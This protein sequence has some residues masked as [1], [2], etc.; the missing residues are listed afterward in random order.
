MDFKSSSLDR[1]QSC[2][3]KLCPPFKREVW[4]SVSLEDNPRDTTR[5]NRATIGRKSTISDLSHLHINDDPLGSESVVSF[6]SMSTKS[7]TAYLRRNVTD[8]SDSTAHARGVSDSPT[9][10]SR[11]GSCPSV[12]S[13]RSAVLE[14]LEPV[15]R[16]LS[17]SHM[18]TSQ[19]TTTERRERIKTSL[20]R[21]SQSVVS[22]AKSISKSNESNRENAPV[23]SIAEPPVN[24]SEISDLLSPLS[25]ISKVNESHISVAPFSDPPVSEK[26]I[27]R[28][29]PQVF[30]TLRIHPGGSAATGRPPLGPSSSHIELRPCQSATMKQ[31][32]VPSEL[33]KTL[34]AIY[35]TNGSQDAMWETFIETSKSPISFADTAS[36]MPSIVFCLRGLIRFGHG[37]SGSGR[38]EAMMQLLHI[39]LR[40]HPICD[41]NSF[42][43]AVE[44]SAAVVSMLC[45]NPLSRQSDFARL[46][47]RSKFE[48]VLVAQNGYLFQQIVTVLS[49]NLPKYVAVESQKDPAIPFMT[50]TINSLLEVVYVY[51]SH[52]TLRSCWL[53]IA[54]APFK[55][56]LVLSLAALAQRF[57]A[58]I[59]RC[60]A[61]LDAI[62][63][64][65]QL[66]QAMC[67]Q[68]AQYLHS[69]ITRSPS[70]ILVTEAT[71]L[72]NKWGG[73][74]Q[75]SRRRSGSFGSFF[76]SISGK[77]K[78]ASTSTKST[79]YTEYN[80][81]C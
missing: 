45:I 6:D 27:T 61:I 43:E 41:T 59:T 48:S 52:A 55:Q 50:R 22:I 51:T 29:S 30:G 46:E 63:D 62:L 9:I 47:P 13:G 36:R 42:L 80:N 38:P 23:N 58:L 49:V 65:I 32:F 44:C 75:G 35:S 19:L 70:P 26:P 73:T 39:L 71:Q 66:E 10:V 57:P 8:L 72:I 69:A 21:L 77:M 7:E 64:F 76:R 34:L 68:I 24:K 5:V 20:S 25:P 40:R 79:V 54:P 3:I 11:R 2:T 17:M 78:N 33:G 37:E 81:L 67:R 12:V 4:E 1:P 53:E 14:P 74:S 15:R 56:S 28:E 18:S 31:P 16:V 60:L